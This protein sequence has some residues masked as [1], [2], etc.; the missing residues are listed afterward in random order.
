MQTTN[1]IITS[2]EKDPTAL[3]RI[4]YRITKL[5]KDIIMLEELLGYILEAL[6]VIAIPPEP[7]EQAGTLSTIDVSVQSLNSIANMI[8]LSHRSCII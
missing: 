8:F 3:E 1:H 7:P 2:G 4:Q 6:E 5:S